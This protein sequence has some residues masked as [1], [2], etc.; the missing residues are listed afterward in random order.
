MGIAVASVGVL[1]TVFAAGLEA[2]F[3]LPG[4]AMLLLAVLAAA[5]QGVLVEKAEGFTGT[6]I[7]YVIQKGDSQ[8]RRQALSFKVHFNDPQKNAKIETQ[9][10]DREPPAGSVGRRPLGSPGGKG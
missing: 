6:E 1:L 3:S 7:T 10:S 9:K 8:N 5:V 4:Y 2:S